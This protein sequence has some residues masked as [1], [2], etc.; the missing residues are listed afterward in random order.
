MKIFTRSK[1]LKRFSKM[2]KNFIPIRK[3]TFDSKIII[4]L[5]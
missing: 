4:F 3:N 2:Q 1:D 5:G